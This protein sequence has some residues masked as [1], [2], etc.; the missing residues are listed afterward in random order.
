MIIFFVTAILKKEHSRYQ[1]TMNLKSCALPLVSVPLFLASTSPRRLELMNQVKI[2]VHVLSPQDID[3]TPHKNESPRA[4][5]RRL[6]QE[7]AISVQGRAKTHALAGFILAADTIV[8]TPRP[9]QILGKPRH[10]QEAEE[11]LQKLSGQTHSVLTGYCLLYFHSS[12][13]GVP[14]VVRVIQSRV[15]LCPLT[16]L[17]IH[18]YVAT[19]EPMDKAGAYAAQG[20][21][22]KWIQSIQG[23]YSN[24]VGLPIAQV[25]MDLESMQ[26]A[27]KVKGMEFA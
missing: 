19:Q 16:P 26:G 25:L 1:Y 14:P 24:I 21:G 3:E 11:M 2:P 18:N 17:A 6:A 15:T 12:E 13:H 7:K 23:S 9:F 5:V 22:M 10:V 8:V 20:Q 27:L 4:L